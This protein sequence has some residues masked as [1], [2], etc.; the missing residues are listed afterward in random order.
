MI[1]WAKPAN[2]I[3]HP[4]YSPM[5]S[6]LILGSLSALLLA[7]L[8]THAQLHTETYNFNGINLDIPDGSVVGAADVQTLDTQV[9]VISDITVHLT[10]EDS[11]GGDPLAYNGDVYAYLSHE[12]GFAVLLNRLGR[13]LGVDL[14]YGDDGVDIMLND[15]APDGDIHLYQDTVVPGSG[16]PLTGLWAPDGRNVDP[17]NVLNTDPRT[18]LLSSFNGLNADGTWTLFVA[19]LESGAQ[20][21]VSDWSMDITGVPE[22]GTAS[23]LA[24]GTLALVRRRRGR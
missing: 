16:L 19:D 8:P 10:I 18:A 21:R 7:A 15:A 20:H 1:W 9:D 3:C 4:E 14:G 24:L 13:I 17:V 11:P 6:H 22:P 23:L 5:K 2:Q 12:S